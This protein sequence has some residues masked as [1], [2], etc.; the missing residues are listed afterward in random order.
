MKYHFDMWWHP[1]LCE[2]FPFDPS[3]G[4]MFL[5]RGRDLVSVDTYLSKNGV[6]SYH[7]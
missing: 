1:H 3:L 5:R 7:G 4:L 2:C 6:P